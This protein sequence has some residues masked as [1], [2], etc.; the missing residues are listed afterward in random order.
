MN[1]NYK[2]AKKY[3]YPVVDIDSAFKSKSPNGIVGEN[4]MV[5]HLHPNLDGYRIMGDE[6]F[7]AMTNLNLLPKGNHAKYK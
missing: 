2:L 7:K 1:R 6:Y 4:L 5:D 3:N